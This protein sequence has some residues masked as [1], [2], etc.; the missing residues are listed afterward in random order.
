MEVLNGF[1][2]RDS[3]AGW[4]N[5]SVDKRTAVRSADDLSLTQA[6]VGKYAHGSTRLQFLGVGAGRNRLVPGQAESVS[7]K[8]NK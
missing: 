8:F 1:S 5:D 6:P 7:F 2:S 3:Q 4:G